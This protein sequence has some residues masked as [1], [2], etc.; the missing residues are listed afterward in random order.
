M[1]TLRTLIFPA[2]KFE[3]LW[4]HAFPGFG[5]FDVQLIIV[6]VM[7]NVVF[8]DNIIVSTTDRIPYQKVESCNTVALVAFEVLTAV[9]MKSTVFL[10]ITSC[11]V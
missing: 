5:I 6:T 2:A 4:D 11:S 7:I 9:V 10:D 1:W 3:F 8:D